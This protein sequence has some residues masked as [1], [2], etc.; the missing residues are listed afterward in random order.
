MSTPQILCFLP[1]ARSNL[2][3][4]VVKAGGIPVIDISLGD[5]VA[6]PAGAWVRTRVRRAVPGKGPVILAG[7]NHKL[8]I[9]NRDTWLETSRYKKTPKGFAGIILRGPNVGGQAGNTDIWDRLSKRT[10]DQRIMLDCALLPTD[11]DK[12]ENNNIEG[13]IL[14]EYLMAL[15]EMLLPTAWK[16]LIEKQ[17]PSLC[18]RHKN[19]SIFAPA[20]SAGIETIALE[21]NW[22]KT[23]T[24]WFQKSDPA[25]CPAPFGS[26]ILH[27]PDIAKHYPSIA[28]L[29]RAYKGDPSTLVEPKN[30][31]PKKITKPPEFKK[32]PIAIIST[33]ASPSSTHQEPIA[34]IGMGCRF[35]DANNPQDFWNNIINQ[36]S[37]IIEVPT[38]RW[39]SSLFWDPD[40]QKEDKT[41]SKVGGFIRSFTFDPKPFRIPPFVLQQVDLVQQL[42]LAST[43]DALADARYHDRDFDRSR[44]AVILGN[45]MGG[46]VSQ[47]YTLRTRLPEFEQAFLRDPVIQSLSSQDRDAMI[48]RVRTQIKETLPK[49]NSDSMPGELSNVIA[50]R[51]ANAFNFNGPNYTLDA[52][53]ASS[54]AAIQ[55]SIKGLRDRE[56]DMVVTGGSDHSMGIP[57]YVKFSKIGALSP[58]HSSPFD[59]RANGFVMG[60]GCGILILKRLRDAQRDGDK[61]YAVIDGMGASSD[62]KGKGITAPNPI[63][64]RYALERAYAASNIEAGSIE[65]VECHG[66]STIVGDQVELET[67]RDIQPSNRTTPLRVGSVKSNIGH[68][69]SAAAAASVIKTALAIYHKKFPPT[70][71]YTTPRTDIE[72]GPIKIQT[73]TEDWSSSIRRAGV[74]AFG[75]GGTNFHLCMSSVPKENT[76][77]QH[78]TKTLSSTESKFP[79][80]WS[81]GGAS[82][83]DLVRKINL[84]DWSVASSDT[85]ITCAYA[86]NLAEYTEQSVRI[87]K[88]HTSNKNPALL[89]GRGIYVI[90]R[91]KPAGKVAF[92]FTGQ[93]SQYLDMGKELCDLFPIVKKTFDQA[94][95][96]LEGQLDKPFIDYIY[97]DPSLSSQEQF[98]MLSDTK[99][100]QPATLC[101]DI[102]LFR[103]LKEH[104]IE[105]DMVAGHSLGEYA[106]AV[107]AGVMSFEDALI[108]VT[109]RGREMANIHLDDPGMMAGIFAQAEALTP[110]LEKSEDYVIAANNNSPNQ[111]VIAGSSAGVQSILKMCKE[112]GFRCKVLPVSHAF[113]SKIVAPATEPLRKVLEKRTISIPQIPMTTN[114]TGSWLSTDPNSIIDT[115]TAQVTHPVEWITQIETMYDAGARVF[116]ECGPQR[117]LTGLVSNILKKRHH[118]I[119]NTNHPKT[120]EQRSF[121]QCIAGFRAIKGKSFI[122]KDSPLAEN[123][124]IKPIEKHSV[125]KQEL[126][127]ILDQRFESLLHAITQKDVKNPLQP[128]PITQS[129]QLP[130][131]IQVV[132]S[133]ASVGL[134]GGTSVFS[135]DNIDALLRGENR[136]SSITE[137]AKKRFLNKNIVRVSKNAQTGQGGF[138][139]VSDTE[140][141]IQLAGQKSYFS[142]RDYD[143]PEE[144][145]QTFDITTKLAFAAGLEALTDARIPLVPRYR[146]GTS[147]QDG[148][149]L[150]QNLQ[151]GTGIIFA[152]AFPGYSNLIASIKTPPKEFNRKFLFQ[153]LSMGHTQFAQ[154]IGAKGPNT[155]VNAACASTTQAIA[156]AQDWLQTQR[157]ERVIVI[158][159]D[160]VTNEEMFEWIGAGFLSVGAATTKSDVEEAA[161][162]FDKRRNGMILGM[163][164]VG[165]VLERRIDVEQRGQ[166]PIAELLGS[167]FSNSAFHGTRLNEDDIADALQEFVEKTCTKNNTTPSD[168]ASKTLFVSHETYTPARGGS[169]SAE[170][171]GLRQ[172]FGSNIDQILI[173]N[174]K[175]ATGHSM[176][177]GI[178]DVLAVKALE[179][180]TVPP[181]PNYKEVDPEL[182]NISL[183][184]GGTFTG[185]Y[186]LRLAAGFG[187]QIAFLLWKTIVPQD[188]PSN[189]CFDTDRQKQWFSSLY[190]HPATLKVQDH[191]LRL[192]PNQQTQISSLPQVEIKDSISMKTPTKSIQDQVLDCI[193]QTTGYDRQDLELDYEL[194][195]DLGI[196]TVKQAEIF[197]TLRDIFQIPTQTDLVLTEVPTI[198]ALCSWFEEN[199]HTASLEKAKPEV[200]QTTPDHHSS[201]VQENDI[202]LQNLDLEITDSVI[203]ESTDTISSVTE[204]LL[205]PR[206]NKRR[207]L[208]S[209]LSSTEELTQPISKDLITESA[210][211]EPVR[212]YIQHDL[213]TTTQIYSVVRIPHPIQKGYSNKFSSFAI[214]GNGQ[215]VD[216]LTKT[217]TSYG[218]IESSNPDLVID[219]SSNPEAGFL[220]AQHGIQPKFWMCITSIGTT[221]HN[222]APQTRLESGSRA[223]LC[224]TLSREWENTQI[225]VVDLSPQ[226]TIQQKCEHILEEL[227]TSEPTQ[228]VFWSDGL[229]SRTEIQL[230][231]IPPLPTEKSTETKTIVI[232]G[233]TRGVCSEIARAF[234]RYSNVRI[235]LLSRTPPAQS[236]LDIDK[237]KENIKTLLKEKNEHVTPAIIREHM[238][239][240]MRA[241]EARRTIEDIQELG[242]DVVFYALDVGNKRD[243]SETIQKITKMWGTIDICIHGAGIEISKRISEKTIQEFRSVY[244][245]KALGGMYLLHSL[246]KS[247]KFISMG[248][249]AG[250][251][252]NTGQADYA[253]A[254]DGLARL[255]SGHPNA[256]H[257]DWSA[258]DGVGMA[259]RGGMS[260]ALQQRGILLLQAQPC[261]ELMV[262]LIRENWSNEIIITDQLG[263]FDRP[264]CEPF[265]D[266][267]QLW[268]DHQ[269]CFVELNLEN[270]PWLKDH[271]INT[272]PVLPGVIGLEIMVNAAKHIWPGTRFCGA[273]SVEY[274]TPIK[275][276]DTL[277][278]EVRTKAVR[279]GVVSCTLYSHRIL[280]NGKNKETEHF[281]AIVQLMPKPETSDLSQRY[282][283]DYILTKEEIYARFFHGPTFQVLDQVY[284]LSTDFLSCEG[285]VYHTKLHPNPLSTA[286]LALE[287][288]F[289]A[290]GLHLMSQSNQVGLP[291]GFAELE[292][293]EAPKDG[294]PLQIVV[295]KEGDRYHVD[296]DTAHIVVL[297]LRGLKFSILGP[298]PDGDKLPIPQKGWTES[299]LVPQEASIPDE[300][301]SFEI[302]QHAQKRRQDRILGRKA[303][304]KLLQNQG[305]SSSSVFNNSLGAPYLEK[306]PK[307]AI[308]IS[309]TNHKGFAALSFHGPIGLDVDEIVP[310]PISFVR[311]CFTLHEQKQAITHH[312]TTAIWCAK[313]A[314]SKLLGIGL[315]IATT[316]IEITMCSPFRANVTLYNHLGQYSYLEIA[317]KFSYRDH[318]CFALA[319]IKRKEC[320]HFRKIG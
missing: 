276:F 74:S 311:H 210:S 264:S 52:A 96:F 86:Q 59:Q 83:S 155:Y 126:N 94:N 301:G 242:A 217:L 55:A 141:V 104:G 300:L 62:G 156:I 114:V 25:T 88:T 207:S 201:V 202:P 138:E 177:A 193:A 120:G 181:I 292:F 23:C 293:I 3:S 13:I 125:T 265:I 291:A 119:L 147:I 277:S 189:R 36:K 260:F 317:V 37:S 10:P 127:Q 304:A 30:P 28:H 241:E 227:Q 281:R 212:S 122:Q 85:W 167:H 205:V 133:G 107:A 4:N 309:H 17:D 99:I 135:T 203:T 153:I 238:A 204:S 161:L 247:T 221:P 19:V 98:S 14:H 106:A 180:R 206:K 45:S 279:K 192:I 267:V 190:D 27:A 224:K 251:F 100:A 70:A 49:L 176:G 310:R 286:P 216:M 226:Y 79:N 113:H 139:H 144:L 270:T 191:V 296:I 44:T 168:I 320:I 266:R 53:C 318:L 112:K 239:P 289:Q 61:I 11:M 244:T 22:W 195:A 6:I 35:P 179:H 151:K 225:R 39:D 54:M 75:F 157:A 174:S 183:S 188:A 93:G 268:G 118:Y 308:S 8:P 258:W 316:D 182:G 1:S 105:P 137:E 123:P 142:L 32:E 223:G 287:A 305:L 295:Y 229:R 273:S 298:L 211:K 259:T 306:H 283:T 67:L 5:R 132:C 117:V 40:P 72:L 149:I 108:S 26:S 58:T 48:A 220:T 38:N 196:D 18:Q 42:T 231:P 271:C 148:W 302:T 95:T 319:H 171:K 250:R 89:R 103:L 237:E 278:L 24:E 282:G 145:L 274:D 92:L 56:F 158:A 47:D 197:S 46:E 235:A 285:A 303:V 159:A 76:P 230:Q 164:A 124:L 269:R 84:R 315:R 312:R 169:A 213:P 90:D 60:E 16:K 109:V 7:E 194:E 29:L 43:E 63:G 41:Y 240:F 102:A 31:S 20:L 200:Q 162:P 134:P 80:I 248:S 66:T 199:P 299:L 163:G 77:T 50:G 21:K 143:I 82:F 97:S 78:D 2:A 152:S 101:M 262:S 253:S 165:M 280:A 297:R 129:T 110:L 170:I 69:K 150:P 178:E 214:I 187:S 314:V 275:L 154:Y 9:R 115:L 51:V 128:Q 209:H 175:G 313:E 246:P 284:E 218:M 184:K 33:T 15:P 294:E 116:V 166:Y 111:T 245:P 232:T 81:V 73:Q 208:S 87:Q 91:R 198:R 68:L 57:T 290:A 257:I 272:R 307:Y 121:M 136:I 215:L 34:I 140:K 234:A 71:N 173:C 172:T 160:D 12:V 185:T 222:V 236:P 186:A 65:L 233:G 219:L 261:A 254:N 131:R 64:Q 243:V 252:G 228:E 130:Q 255:C 288:A 249:I 263:D 256:L 146:K